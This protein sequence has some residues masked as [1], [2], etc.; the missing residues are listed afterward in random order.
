MIRC[1]RRMPGA[2]LFKPAGI[3]ASFLEEI[4]LTLEE[5]ETIRLKDFEGLCQTDAAEKMKIS[6]PTFQRS[7]ENARKKIAAALVE[8]KSLKIEGGNYKFLG[9]HGRMGR[10]MHGRS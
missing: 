1:V 4:I 5:F 7:Y 3:P 6:Q 10:R 9:K 8:G 2:S